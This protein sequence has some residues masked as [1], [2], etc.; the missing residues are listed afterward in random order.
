MSHSS[1]FSCVCLSSPVCLFPQCVL[2][3]L[4]LGEDINEKKRFLSGIARIT[5]TQSV[6]QGRVYHRFGIFIIIIIFI[7]SIRINIFRF[8]WSR[9]AHSTSPVWLET[10]RRSLTTFSGGEHFRLIQVV[11]KLYYINNKKIPILIRV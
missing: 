7:I 11:Y 1:Q 10:L 5:Q 4:W 9:A 2:F 3:P 8:T 6:L